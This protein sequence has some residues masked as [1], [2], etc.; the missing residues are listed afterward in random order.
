MNKSNTID[1]A[2]IAKNLVFSAQQ[3][4]DRIPHAFPFILLDKIIELG[5]KHI[6]GIKNV[7]FNEWF[8][9]GHFPGNPI[10]PGVLML[11]GMTQTGGLLAYERIPGATIKGNYLL[12]IDKVKFRSMVRPGDTLF[13]YIQLGDQ[14]RRGMYFMTCE[15]YVDNK[16]VA[17]AEVSLFNE[18]I[19]GL[20]TKLF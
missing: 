16:K 15:A 13:Y 7:S 2:A 14:V 19:A 3:I 9:Q 5:E 12:K 10:M 6:I 4:A 17:E 1:F 18:N 20:T 8:F 11:E